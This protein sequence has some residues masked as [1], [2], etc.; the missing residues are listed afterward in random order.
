MAM[1]GIRRTPALRNAEAPI[2]ASPLSVENGGS[3]RFSFGVGGGTGSTV[4]IFFGERI[5][6]GAS[7]L[8]GQASA[9]LVLTFVYL[10]YS[11]K[12]GCKP[13]QLCCGAQRKG[14]RCPP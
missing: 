14:T 8:V 12:T 10:G 13:V 7:K 2:L 9:C 6:R 11:K 1:S 4:L 3:A 5:T